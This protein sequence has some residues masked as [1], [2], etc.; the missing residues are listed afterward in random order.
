MTHTWCTR[1][2]SPLPLALLLMSLVLRID[3][4][5]A[6]RSPQTLEANFKRISSPSTPLQ[7]AAFAD[8]DSDSD[9]DGV[10]VRVESLLAALHTDPEHRGGDT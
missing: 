8:A 1:P 7:S 3:P 2:L 9:S 4:V 6:F 10:R 5:S